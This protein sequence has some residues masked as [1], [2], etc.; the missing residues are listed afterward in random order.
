M[1]L[2]TCKECSHQI[3]KTAKFCPNCGAKNKQPPGCLSVIIIGLILFFVIGVFVSISDANSSTTSTRSSVRREA[4]YNSSDGSVFEVKVFLRKTLKDPKSYD[5]MAWG[6]V[7]K[8]KDGSFYVVHRYRAK[9]SF[10]GYVIEQK[11]FRFD[12]RGN[13]ESVEDP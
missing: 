7:V 8:N 4:V 10:G 5:P 6:K 9:N 2:I 12:R 3:S 11:I 1:S 13:I